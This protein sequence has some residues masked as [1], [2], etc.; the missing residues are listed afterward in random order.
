[1]IKYTED[2]RVELL[3][4]GTDFFPALKAAIDGAEHDIYV[5]TY[6][7][8]DDA[9]GRNIANALILAARRNVMVHVLVDGF[10]SRDILDTL[11]PEMQREGVQVLVYRRELKRFS[12]NRRRLRRLH[13]KV[14]VIDGSIAFVGGINIIDDYQSG[15]L[16]APRLDYAVRVEG[17]LLRPIHAAVL[18]MWR[19]VSW[20]SWRRRQPKPAVR[21]NL[22]QPV[23]GIRAAFVVRGKLRHRGAIEDAYLEMINNARQEIIIASAYFFPGRRFRLALLRAARRGV[24]VTL[25]LQGVTDHPAMWY[26][27]RALHPPLLACGMRVFEYELSEL[28]AKVAV[29]DRRWATVG[30]SNIDPFSLLLAREANVFVDDAGFAEKLRGSLM[31]AMDA[32]FAELRSEEHQRLPWSQRCRCWLAY[33]FVRICTD[34]SGA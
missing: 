1:M 21:K 15:E 11:V 5:E 14:A 32:G 30:S 4:S 12:L 9:T 34:L 10:G 31:R 17:P 22:Y 7:F 28:H 3:E 13:R 33:H 19:L 18:R 2:N 23:G 24:K 20:V 6:I 25:L 16:E 8:C 29:V 26:A 27:T